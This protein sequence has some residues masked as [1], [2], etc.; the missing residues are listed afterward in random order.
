MTSGALKVLSFLYWKSI[1][2][3]CPW[4]MLPSDRTFQL[5]WLGNSFCSGFPDSSAGRESACSVGDLGSIPGLGRFPRE[6]KGYPLQYS[7]LENSM[8]CIVHGVTKSRTWLSDFHFPFLSSPFLS[9]PCPIHTGIQENQASWLYTQFSACIWP[10]V[11]RTVCLLRCLQDPRCYSL[12]SSPPVMLNGPCSFEVVCKMYFLQPNWKVH[13]NIPK[14]LEII[15]LIN[16][17]VNSA[18][19]IK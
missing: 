15:V 8:D 9:W 14:H 16:N 12:A 3:L 5:W 6:G 1:S 18:P 10:W 2:F 13:L 11:P 4:T 19:A 17:N 7:G